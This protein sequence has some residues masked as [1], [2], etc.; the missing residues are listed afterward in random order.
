METIELSRN[1]WIFLIL[2][3]MLFTF[4]SCTKD[5]LPAEEDISSELMHIEEPNVQIEPTDYNQ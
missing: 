3:V 1:N 5:E 2:A 4:I